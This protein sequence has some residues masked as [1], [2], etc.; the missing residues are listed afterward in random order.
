MNFSA[1]FYHY[2]LHYVTGTNA[3]PYCSLGTPLMRAENRDV[4]SPKWEANVT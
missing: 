2:T 1:I 3:W 4:W